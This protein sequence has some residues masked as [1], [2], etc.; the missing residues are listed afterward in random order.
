M[1]F[2]YSKFAADED[3]RELL[4]SLVADLPDRLEAL[5]NAVAKSDLATLARLVHQ[6]KGACGSYGYEV[7]TPLARQLEQA[8]KANDDMEVWA[9]EFKLFREAISRMTAEPAPDGKLGD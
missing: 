9:G 2:I 1:T 7:I 6:L 5:D 3:W 8:M 4:Q